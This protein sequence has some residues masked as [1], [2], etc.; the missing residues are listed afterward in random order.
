MFIMW[1]DLWISFSL[2]LTRQAETIR[3]TTGQGKPRVWS[4]SF[5]LE[6]SPLRKTECLEHEMPALGLKPSLH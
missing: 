6:T 1:V 4:R 3:E 5:D 2:L